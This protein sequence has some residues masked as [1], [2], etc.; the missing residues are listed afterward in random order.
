MSLDLSGTWRAVL[1]DDEI[2]RSGLGLDVDDSGWEAIQVP[3][4]WARHPAF[5]GSNGPLLYRTRFEFDRPQPASRA[6]VV[7]DGIFYQGDVWLDGAYLGDPE[8]Y[9][10]PHSFDITDL[11]RLSR[12]HVLAVEVTCSP[13]RDRRAKRN[14]TGAFQHS[15]LIDPDWNPG[16]L[17]RPVR[18]ETTGPVRIETLRVLTR[19]LSDERANVILRAQLD[20]DASRTA[21]LRTLVD[22]QLVATQ[23]RTLATGT[24]AV[25]WNIDIDSPRIWWPWALGDQ[26]MTEITVE[27]VADG[28]PSHTRRVRTGL[29]EV[30]FE[31]WTLSVN[32]ERLFVK[33]AN[34]APTRAALGEAGP[35]EIRRDVELAR[36]AGLDLLR[37]HGHVGRQEL[38]DAADE[39]GML[40]WQD[41]PMH[42]GYARMVRTQAVRQAEAS[43][44]RASCARMAS[45]GVRSEDEDFLLGHSSENSTASKC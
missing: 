12:E 32:G 21:T 24:N 10:F 14:L 35:A 16:G 44:E 18:I 42:G 7:L 26:A 2:R 22:G 15:D 37:V 20:S 8:G 38:Y 25:E 36:D 33:G 13:Q 31:D 4:H 39:L 23:A 43:L 6:W 27:V 5:A 11:A 3:G 45:S 40:V 9:C 34:L 30:A 1:A 29:R 28:A 19:D 41:F 17:W